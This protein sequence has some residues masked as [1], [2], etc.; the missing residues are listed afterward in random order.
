MTTTAAEPLAVYTPSDHD[1]WTR[2]PALGHY[3]S[4]KIG[5]AMTL[6][7]LVADFGQYGADVLPLVPGDP[8]PRGACRSTRSSST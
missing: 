7:E 5:V 2:D 1:V 3:V 4:F 6:P 8:L